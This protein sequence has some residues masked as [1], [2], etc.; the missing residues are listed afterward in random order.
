MPKPRIVPGTY[1]C[2]VNVCFLNLDINTQVTCLDFLVFLKHF[3]YLL[4]DHCF[5]WVADKLGF[6]FL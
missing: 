2:S 6:G 5:S 4:S 1:G 3:S